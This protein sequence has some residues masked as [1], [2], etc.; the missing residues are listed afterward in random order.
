MSSEEIN[1]GDYVRTKYGITQY[2]EYETAN[3][4]KLLCMPVKDGSN[5]IFANI[6]DIIKSSPNI[7]DLIQKNDYVNGMKVF[8]VIKNT[9]VDDIKEHL[10]VFINEI[11]NELFEVYGDDIKSIVTKE[12]FESIE[13]KVN[14]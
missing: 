10:I 6:E 3:G 8:E 12:Q 7:I 4:N 5:G 9:E 14:K 11:K 13:Y 2:K 1:I